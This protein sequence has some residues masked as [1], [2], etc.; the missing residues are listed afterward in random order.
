M[1]KTILIP[2]ICVLLTCLLLCGCTDPAVPEASPTPTAANDTSASEPTQPSQT[3]PIRPPQLHNELE[4]VWVN[5][6]EYSEGRDFVE[7]LTIRSDYTIRVHLDYQGKAY[8]DLTGTYLLVGKT[9]TFT[10]DDGTVRVYD[11]EVD[12]TVLT[13]TGDDRTVIY[14]RSD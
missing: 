3:Q 8:N 11:Y 12:G 10:L 9:L 5:A 13:L 1:K 14:R 4:G 7:T 6:G 2:M